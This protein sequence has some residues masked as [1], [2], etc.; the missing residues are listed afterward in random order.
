MLLDYGWPKELRRQQF[1]DDFNDA[2]TEWRKESGFQRSGLTIEGEYTKEKRDAVMEKNLESIWMN[3]LTPELREQALREKAQREA[4][5][6][7]AETALQNLDNMN[8]S[9]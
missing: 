6:K 7:E 9:G 3:R 2:Y 5:E 8:M 4:Q 1:L